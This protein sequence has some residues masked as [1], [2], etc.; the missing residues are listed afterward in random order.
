M[1]RVSSFACA[2][3]VLGLAACSKTYIPN[4][5]V[6]DNG[7]NRRV[8]AFCE[9]YRHAV[10]ERNV[11]QLMKMLSPAYHEDGGNTRGEDDLDHDGIKDWLTSTFLKTQ[12]IRYEIRYRRV[13]TTEAKRILVDYTYAGSYRHPGVKQE[14]WRHTVADNRLVLVPDGET[15]KIV[16]GL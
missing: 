6:E 9:D 4:T 15:F 10:E 13:T 12:N 7:E 8:I 3:A 1:R 16:S 5:D 14:E 11:G 2:F